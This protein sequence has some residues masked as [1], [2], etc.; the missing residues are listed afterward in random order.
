MILEAPAVGF[1][2]QVSSRGD[3][4]YPAQKYRPGYELHTKV[5]NFYIF[6]VM[7]IRGNWTLYSH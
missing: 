2:P 4:F 5:Q 1:P 6:S 3:F 7:Y